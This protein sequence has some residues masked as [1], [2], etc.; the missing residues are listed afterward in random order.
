M[1]QDT[2]VVCNAK[3]GL[4]CSRCKGP[5]YC[6]APCQQTHWKVHKKSCG[7]AGILCYT[8]N[9]CAEKG[10]FVEAVRDIVVGEL[11]MD[12]QALLVVEFQ[13]GA[14]STSAAG[15]L[16]KLPVLCHSSRGARKFVM[17]V[18]SFLDSAVRWHASG[19]GSEGGPWR[20]FDLHCPMERV[21]HFERKEMDDLAT[22]V[23]A[24]LP[25]D[26]PVALTPED[27]VRLVVTFRDNALDGGDGTYSSLF[28]TACR[29]EHSCEPNAYHYLHSRTHITLRAIAPI[30]AGSAISIAYIPYY[31]PA[32][33]RRQALSQHYYFDCKCRMCTVGLDVAR[34]FVC[35]HC[36]GVVCPVGCSTDRFLCRDCCRGVDAQRCTAYRQA[37]ARLLRDLEAGTDVDLIALFDEQLLHRIHHL[38]YRAM[39]QRVKQAAAREHYSTVILLCEYLLQG[40]RQVCGEYSEPLYSNYCLMGRTCL[41]MGRPDDAQRAFQ[42]AYAIA[43][44]S[45]GP[46]S[47][48]CQHALKALKDLLAAG[49]NPG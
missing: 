12:E 8:I 46:T 19:N 30:S 23:A 28:A 7:R 35:L 32:Y 3:A 22:V 13:K 34:A 45:C 37:E 17:V 27:M 11:I 14:L 49:A 24:T 18:L 20:V 33:D 44:V 31:L 25:R 36:K 47:D 48:R 15:T 6:S 9:C 39:V 38:V 29:L 41:N 5:L 42:R 43:E 4:R 2:C 26:S 10:K 40:A 1:I 16:E 21:N